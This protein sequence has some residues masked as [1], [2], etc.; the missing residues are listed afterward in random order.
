MLKRNLRFHI[1]ALTDTAVYAQVTY[2][3][4]RRQETV[5]PVYA[6]YFPTL[7]EIS[8]WYTYQS[9]RLENYFLINKAYNIWRNALLPGTEE[10]YP[11]LK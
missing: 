8:P 6:I 11:W 2:T 5:I 10:K 1:L 9:N 7:K 4:W 3:N